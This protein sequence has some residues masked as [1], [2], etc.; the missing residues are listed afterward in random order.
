[1]RETTRIGWRAAAVALAVTVAWSLAPARG[2]V[3]SAVP[4]TVAIWYRGSPP[5]VPVLDD[6]AVIQAHGL[7][8]VMWP[9]RF[10]SA[11][12]EVRRLAS[13]VGLQVV[14]GRETARPLDASRALAP[15]DRETMAVRETP[16]SH[17]AALAWRALAHG[18]RVVAI[19]DGEH[20]GARLSGRGGRP[21][22]W[23][24]GAVALA[25]QVSANATLMDR[26]RPSLRVIVDGVP[27]LDLDV[28]LLQADRAW[29]VVATNTGSRRI[30]TLARLPAPVPY[31]LWVSW[32]D[33]SSLAMRS[34]PAGPQ[35]SLD[36]VPGEARVYIIDSSY[37]T[38]SGSR[39]LA[40]PNRP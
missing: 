33:G 6:L 40:A 12:A 32:I 20:S 30:R 14:L 9:E 4:P 37:A 19:D 27:S 24:R 21:L 3:G 36:L 8:G 16:P 7:T 38:V 13:T 35:W 2:Q 34:T 39:G 17:L 10:L 11:E 15:G 28:V 26:L 1:M 31:A 22:D 25:R 18:A 29:V 5:G 23:V